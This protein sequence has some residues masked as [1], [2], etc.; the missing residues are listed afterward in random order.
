ME[1]QQSSRGR[2]PAMNYQCTVEEKLRKVVPGHEIFEDISLV[3]FYVFE[4]K[5]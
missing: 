2:I 1:T 3:L 5:Q 4:Y